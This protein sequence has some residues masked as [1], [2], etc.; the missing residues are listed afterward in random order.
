MRRCSFFGDVDDLE[1]PVVIVEWSLLKT[2]AE[3][4]ISHGIFPILLDLAE[5]LG[6]LR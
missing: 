6:K 1:I 4:S 3:N 2:Y 5:S